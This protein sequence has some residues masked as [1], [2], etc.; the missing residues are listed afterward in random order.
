MYLTSLI[1]EFL[2]LDQ[3]LPQKL[4]ARMDRRYVKYIQGKKTFLIYSDR[5]AMNDHISGVA[6]HGRIS[7]VW[8]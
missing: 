8:C 6:F 5:I 2:D 7:V 1:S 3:N 4:V